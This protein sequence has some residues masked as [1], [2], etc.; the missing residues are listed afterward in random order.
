MFYAF[1]YSLM[2]SFGITLGAALYGWLDH[3]ATSATSCTSNVPSGYRFLFVPMFT[4]CLALINQATLNQLPLMII[5]SEVGYM[6]NYFSSLHFKTASEL[7]AT[8][9]CFVVGLLSNLY[10]RMNKTLNRFFKNGTFMTVSLMLPAIFVQVP[11]GIA[12]Q[13]SLMVGTQLADEITHSNSSS[14]TSSSTDSTSTMNFGLSMI[15]VALGISVGLFL[16][17]IVVYPTGK[18]R[19]GLF[20]L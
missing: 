14:S 17:T 6:V 15:Q 19:T 13:G 11:S 7:N 4:I 18:K 16:S 3:N 2:L 12:S 5:I 8:L 9:G 10:T 1:I 20:T